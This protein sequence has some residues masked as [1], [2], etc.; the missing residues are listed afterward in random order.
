MVGDF[1]YI[2]VEEYKEL[3]L[4][5]YESTCIFDN[6]KPNDVSFPKS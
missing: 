6:N 4:K 5:K 2:M 1:S 3:E